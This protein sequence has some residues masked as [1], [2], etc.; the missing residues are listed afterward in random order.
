VSKTPSSTTTTSTT[1]PP[2]YL[3]PYLQDAAQQ[4]RGLYLSGGPQYYPGYQTVGFSPQTQQAFDMTTQRALAG[5][6]GIA[7]AE[8]NNADTLQGKYLYGGQGFNA[9]VKAAT[10]YAMPQVQ[11]AFSTAGRTRSGL[12]QNAMANT[13]ASPFAAQYGQERENQM[14]AQAMAPM[15]AEA[16]YMDANKLQGVGSQ[17][18]QLAQDRLS[19]DVARYNYYQNAPENNLARYIGFLQGSYP[20]QSASQ[21]QPVY[22]NRTAGALGGAVSGATAGSYISPG[23]GTLIGAIGGGLLGG[24]G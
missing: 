6:P 12:A 17:V 13:I 8:Q 23:W 4:A 11:S 22:R 3:Q 15:L 1:E 10:D 19:E 16:G 18:E 21:T 20:G 24:Y 5:S 9:A 14:R 2:A 7:A